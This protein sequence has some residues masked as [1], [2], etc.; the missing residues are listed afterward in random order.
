MTETD[1]KDFETMA[2]VALGLMRA[3]IDRTGTTLPVFL[4]RH[5]DGRIQRL[6]FPEKAGGLMNDGVAK[7]K[8]FQFVRQVVHTEDITAVCFAHE[9]WRGLM[10]EAGSKVPRKEFEKATRERGFQK[11]VDLGW[12][13][14]SEVIAITIQTAEAVRIIWQIFERD[15]KARTIT[16]IGG[17]E[18]HDFPQTKFARKCT[19][20]CARRI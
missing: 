6:P 9:A 14:R 17:P 18:V 4:F 1:E 15:E 11:A 20:I 8:L 13:Q 16:L 19:A 12:V 5:A 3:Y 2:S 10:T 7:D